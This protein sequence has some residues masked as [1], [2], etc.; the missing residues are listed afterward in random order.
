[1]NNFSWIG[2]LSAAVLLTGG[3]PPAQAQ[4]PPFGKFTVSGDGDLSD[5]SQELLIRVEKRNLLGS[6]MFLFSRGKV[7]QQQSTPYDLHR[8]GGEF[9]IGWELDPKTDLQVGYR[10]DSASV[11][12]VSP[13][14]DAAYRDVAGRSDVGALGFLLVRDIRDD[15][16]CATCGSRFRLGGELAVRGWGGDYNFG[17]LESDLAL[18]F[19]PLRERAADSV[20]EDLIFVEHLRVGWMEDFGS[21]DEVPFFERY[22]V[23]GANTVRGHRGDWLSPRRIDDQ[24]IG[25][26][27]ELVNNVE[28]RLPLFK[29]TF[30]RRL[31][32]IAFFDMGRSYRRFSQIGD[33]GYGAGVGLHYVV[34]FWK[35]DGVLRADFGVNLARE[36]D[37]SLTRLNIKFG[38]PF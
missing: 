11:F 4:G 26:E 19:T 6:P 33:F 27:V 38:A 10:K 8:W 20:W 16:T 28:A 5:D 1:M 34:H 35:I 23:G 29:E 9:G 32:A 22:F 2:F 17:R 7:G 36:D 37:D 13:D 30:H 15:P 25:G 3:V 21:S 31:F 18:Y 24:F 12:N 14:S